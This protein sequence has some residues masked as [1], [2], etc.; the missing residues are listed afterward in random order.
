MMKI[1]IIGTGKM[2]SWLARALSAG[3]TIAVYNRHPEKALELAKMVD[4][5]TV[6]SSPSELAGFAPQLLINAVALK[7]TVQVFEECAKYVPKDCVLCDMASIKSG[8]PEYYS[9]CGF[10]FASIHPMFGPT[11]ADMGAVKGENAV[12]IKESDQ[13]TAEF[14]SRFLSGLGVRLFFYTF[15]EHDRTMAYSLT[16][17]FVSSIVF[18]AC[19]DSAAVPG[20]TFAKHMKIA[21][22]LMSEDTTLLNEILFNPYSVKELE[23]VTSRLEYLKHIIKGRDYEE[24]DRFLGKLANNIKSGQG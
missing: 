19:V 16:L 18:A 13:K 8:L 1:A 24:C 20:T 3:N 17:P 14:F 2:G 10:R 4:G 12:I 11:F 23:K 9:K 5:L 15:D 22:G 7:S 21:K 6:L